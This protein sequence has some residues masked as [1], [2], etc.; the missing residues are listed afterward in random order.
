MFMDIC[1][2]DA[3]VT[4]LFHQ[5]DSCPIKRY[6][7]KLGLLHD[8]SDILEKNI[9]GELPFRD[10]VVIF[11]QGI[12]PARRSAV[13][14]AVFVIPGRDFESRPSCLTDVRSFR[15]ITSSRYSRQPR[16][17]SGSSRLPQACSGSAVASLAA[18]TSII[19]IAVNAV[20]LT[21]NR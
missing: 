8:S 2:N 3:K 11:A 1:Q 20:P 12:P 21:G 5:T 9:P 6:S 16:R 17:T 7:E 13:S 14:R 4:A 18:L 19:L 15:T 10:S